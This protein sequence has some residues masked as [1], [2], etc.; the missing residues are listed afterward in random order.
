MALVKYGV[1]HKKERA[2]DLP[3]LAKE[4]IKV[5]KELDTLTQQT[6]VKH[7]K[8]IGRPSENLSQN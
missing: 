3:K 8:H 6:G 7:V 1:K 2:E 5:S 4:H